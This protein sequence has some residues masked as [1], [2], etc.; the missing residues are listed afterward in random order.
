M[1]TPLYSKCPSYGPVVLYDTLLSSPSTGDYV[2]VL[3]IGLRRTRDIHAVHNVR[4]S[5]SPSRSSLS[6][7]LSS[8]PKRSPYDGGKKK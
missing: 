1:R 8:S 7:S 4:S 6:P 3:D 2:E 5:L